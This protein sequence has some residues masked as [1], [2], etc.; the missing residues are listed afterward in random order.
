VLRHESSFA[1]LG[2]EVRDFREASRLIIQAGE[3]EAFMFGQAVCT[4]GWATDGHTETLSQVISEALTQGLLYTYWLE[5]GDVL[6]PVRVE[7]LLGII[8]RH[9]AIDAS[10][11]RII[12]HDWNTLVCAVLMFE[13]QHS[14]PV[15]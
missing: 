5:C 2:G 7:I 9:S 13:E 3:S 15:I 6:V 11:Q 1:W 4:L 14:S 12:R 10:R 8:D